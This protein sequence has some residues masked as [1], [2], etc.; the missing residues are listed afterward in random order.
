MWINTKYLSLA[1]NFFSS[2]R[3]INSSASW[4][5]S[6][7]WLESTYVSSLSP[8]S[9]PNL[10][11]LLISYPSGCNHYAL[12]P[13]SQKIERHLDFLLH[14][15]HKSPV[16]FMSQIL[17]LSSA[18]LHPHATNLVQDIIIFCLDHYKSLQSGLTTSIHF[19]PPLYFPNCSPRVISLKY[20]SYQVTPLLKMQ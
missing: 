5:S 20:K 17:L 10:H 7:R 13:T 16:D 19:S 3:P 18:F 6:H 11:F 2:Y 8:L 15:A 12:I 1:P 14:F 9:L 4:I